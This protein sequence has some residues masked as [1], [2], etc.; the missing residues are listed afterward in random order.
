M[1]ACYLR[2]QRG[3]M[4]YLDEGR[5]AARETASNSSEQ[6]QRCRTSSKGA[7]RLRGCQTDGEVVG[8]GSI[9]E[10]ALVV[11]ALAASIAA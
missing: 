2:L 7:G 6:Q 4:L 11:T 10:A 8:E 1:S 3:R 9:G 5:A